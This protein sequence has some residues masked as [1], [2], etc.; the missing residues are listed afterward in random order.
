MDSVCSRGGWRASPP[1]AA[2]TAPRRAYRPA[3]P[4]AQTLI[5]VLLHA[6][7]V[8][9]HRSFE[10]RPHEKD[11]PAGTVV[12]ILEVQIGRARLETES[13]VHARVDAGQRVGERSAGQGATRHRG[14]TEQISGEAA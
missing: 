3:R 14:A 6:R 4:A 7:I 8:W 2:R 1:E 9:F 10:Q 11:S 13:A 5:D 12:L